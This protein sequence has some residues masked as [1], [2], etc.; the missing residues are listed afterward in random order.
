MREIWG[1]YNNNFWSIF[2]IVVKL[3]KF[4]ALV[5]EG[6]PFVISKFIQYYYM[7]WITQAVYIS[8]NYVHHSC[9]KQR[10]NIVQGAKTIL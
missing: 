8:T 3:S 5:K 1:I 7:C 10:I 4:Q 2:Y 6:V 9:V